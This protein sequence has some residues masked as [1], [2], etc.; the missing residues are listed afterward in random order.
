MIKGLSKGYIYSPYCILACFCLGLLINT[1]NIN[2]Q[3]STLP[4]CKENKYKYL[5]ICCT[6]NELFHLYF[7]VET[8]RVQQLCGLIL[9][10][11]HVA[12][13]KHFEN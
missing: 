11:D 6:G 12:N 7:L 1:C 10:S 8:S 13:Q 9:F 3:Y 2:L 4:K 5:Y